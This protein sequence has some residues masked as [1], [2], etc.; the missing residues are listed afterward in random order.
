VVSESIA[1]RQLG[2]RCAA[3][4]GGSEPD[5]TLQRGPL[6]GVVAAGRPRG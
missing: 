3:A 2:K 5:A 1:Q 4:T 6:A